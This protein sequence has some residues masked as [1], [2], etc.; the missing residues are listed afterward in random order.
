MKYRLLALLI[1]GFLLTGC[2]GGGYGGDSASGSSG[3]NTTTAPAAGGGGAAVVAD[4][5]LNG[6][7]TAGGSPAAA[8]LE[9]TLVV[10]VQAVGNGNKYF[11]D[12][13][14][15]DTLDLE[16]G[17]TYTLDQSDNSNAGHPLRFS[18]TDNGTHSGGVEYTA[19]ITTNGTAGQAGAYTRIAATA[20]TPNALFYYCTNHA[21]MG[22]QAGVTNVGGANNAAVN[23]VQGLSYATETQS[24]ITDSTGAFTYKS[25]ETIQFS[26]G[27]FL[28]GDA[29]LA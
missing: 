26:I 18:T 9:Q 11:I 22:G 20:G 12:G 17:I 23:G 8:S 13:V 28:L 15:Q 2:G 6:Q 7:F 29:V 5:V 3:Y 4:T 19:D 27:N 14:Q 10:T 25:G 24:G 1:I 21:G 16:V